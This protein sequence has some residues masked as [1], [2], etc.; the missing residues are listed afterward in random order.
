MSVDLTVTC[1]NS[2][3]VGSNRLFVVVGEPIR[4]QA[5]VRTVPI[6]SP[7]LLS[8]HLWSLTVLVR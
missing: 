5:G 7:C 4:T 3:S 8:V 6:P 1:S 2:F